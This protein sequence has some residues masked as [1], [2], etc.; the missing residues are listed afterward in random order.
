MAH[1]HYGSSSFTAKLGQ[2]VLNFGFMESIIRSVLITLS[3]SPDLAKAFTLPKNSVSQNLELLARLCRSRVDEQ[4]VE[5][6]ITAIQETQSLFEERNY[7]FHGMFFENEEQIFL[8][9]MKKG[10][11]GMADE[12]VSKTYDVSKLELVLIRLSERRRQF[13][14]FL[15]DYSSSDFGPSHTPSQT[16]HP[17]LHIKYI[18]RT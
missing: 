3:R 2:A 10:K 5:N 13:M 7:I 11:R 8:A 4:Y 17:S 12:W 9:K 15:D 1:G 6:W 14:D 18:D 16:S